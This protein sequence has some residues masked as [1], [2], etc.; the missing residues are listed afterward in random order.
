M[1]VKT[2]YRRLGLGKQLADAMLN[3]ARITGYRCVLP[4]TL[5][6]MQTVRALYE[7]LGFAEIPSYH[8]NP[9]AGAHCLKVDL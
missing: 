8:H 5:D 6:D 7:D 2:A 3:A 9:I 1:Y 4:D